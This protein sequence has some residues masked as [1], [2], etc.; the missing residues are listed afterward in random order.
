MLRMRVME[1]VG[2]D[3]GYFAFEGCRRGGVVVVK[4]VCGKCKVFPVR[5][6]EDL[7]READECGEFFENFLRDEMSDMC[8]CC[9]DILKC[10][11][12]SGLPDSPFDWFRVSGNKVM[13]HGE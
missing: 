13:R 5:D 4:N 3:S 11:F 6:W 9:R 12:V 8:G 1:V 10:G 7:K 2:L